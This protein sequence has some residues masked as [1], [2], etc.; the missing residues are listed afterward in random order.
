VSAPAQGRFRRCST[1]WLLLPSL[2][3][4]AWAP[5]TPSAPP[6]P[7][8]REPRRVAI[9]APLDLELAP[10]LAQARIGERRVVAGQTHHLGSLAGHPV[11]LVRCGR[12]LVASAASTQAVLDHHAVRAIVVTGIAGGVDPA[13]GVGDVVAPAAWAQYQEH[14]VGRRSA[15][16]E[17]DPGP[18][19]R[20]S[21]PRAFGPFFTRPQRL[22]WLRHGEEA[23]EDRLWF[24][25]DPGMLETARRSGDTTPLDRCAAD[26]RCAPTPPRF[27]AGGRGVS[28][29]GFVDNAEYR[30]WIWESFG[31]SA[32]DQETAA[33][34]QVAYTN[35]VPFLAFRGLSDLAGG[36]SGPNEAAQLSGLAATNAARAVTAFLDRWEG[37]GR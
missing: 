24:E 1:A 35:G 21:E 17:Y 36:G 12:S 13:H 8:P 29:N 6:Q 11:V 19:L 4:L 27:A 30:G 28:G 3:V 23:L 5:Q 16:G 32:V 7:P 26:G 31:A 10:L 15:S 20:G 33:I 14:V 34:A 9:L 25:A 2:A 18:F 22:T 37:S